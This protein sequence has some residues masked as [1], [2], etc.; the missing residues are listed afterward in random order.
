MDVQK[1]LI[2]HLHSRIT[3]DESLQ[4]IFGG[5]VRLSLIF[6]PPDSSLPHITHRLDLRNLTDWI[7]VRAGTYIVDIWSI[8]PNAEEALNIRDCI[9]TLIHDH[10]FVAE[11]I[12]L[13]W[14]WRQ[15]DGFIPD[16]S[17]IWHYAIQFNFRYQCMADAANILRR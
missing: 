2:N 16:E 8:S 11:G 1:V 4:T 7:P 13:A 3:D 17:G 6:A 10:E 9:M 12:D 5:N 15:T 14:L